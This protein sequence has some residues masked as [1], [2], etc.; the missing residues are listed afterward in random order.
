VVI[1]SIAALLKGGIFS[2]IGVFLRHF[3]SMIAQQFLSLLSSFKHEACAQ[4]Q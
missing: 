4:R 2:G 3:F 1:F